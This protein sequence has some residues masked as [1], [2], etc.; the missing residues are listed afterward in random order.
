MAQAGVA[1]A[2]AVTGGTGNLG[3]TLGVVV[4]CR[5]EADIVARKVENLARADWPQSSRP[6]RI[7]IVDDGSDDGTGERARAACERCAAAF[8]QRGVQ[9]AVVCNETRPGKPGAIQAGLDHLAGDGDL[10]VR[11][12]LVVLTDADVSIEKE[13]LV[14]LADAFAAGELAMACG[15]QRFVADLAGDGRAV[16]AGG[17][18]LVDRGAVFDRLTARVRRLES[19][20]GRLF[21]VHGQLLAWRAALE[22]A[23]TPGIAADDI[24]LMLQVR[25]SHAADPSRAWR[26]ELVAS[27]TFLEIKTEEPARAAE[28]ELRRARAYVQ[29]VRAWDGKPAARG[30]QWA[31]YRNVPLAAP[32]ATVFAVALAPALGAALAG[33]VGALLALAIVGAAA[34]TGRGRGW[35]RLVRRIHEANRM[36]RENVLPERWEMARR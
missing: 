27:A 20:R 36:Q 9:V 6:H 11:C 12:D 35:L 28:Q 18:P 13:T 14:A 3:H 26:V 17:E 7:A 15:A 29:V 31:F 8:A 30:F 10:Q 25:E 5:N 16:G 22:L 19:Q 34:A 24:D 1:D 4:P 23:P 2:Q 32:A 21:S 33:T